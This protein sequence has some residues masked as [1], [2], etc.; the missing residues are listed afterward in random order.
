MSIPDP[1]CL[2]FPRPDPAAA[3]LE[4]AISAYLQS[5]QRR[6][7]RGQ[8]ARAHLDNVTRSLRTFAEAW[9]VGFADG[10]RAVLP[11]A[12]LGPLQRGRV[13]RRPPPRTAG[14]AAAAIAWALELFPGPSLGAQAWRNGETLI[15]DATTD[16]LDL[17][18]VANSQWR[19]Q[20]A[21]A[22]VCAAIL[23]CFGWY[24]DTTGT[25]SPYRRRLAPKFHRERRRNA[26][27]AE[28][29]AMRG[30]GCSEALSLALWCLWHLDGVRPDEM[31]R[32]RWCQFRWRGPD[33]STIE[34]PHKTQRY[35]GKPKVVP[36]TPRAHDFFGELRRTA[37]D[38]VVFHNTKG[39]AWNRISFDGSFRRRR[40]SIGLPDDLTPYC[41]R[42]GY[43]TDAIRGRANKQDVAILLGHTSTRM[44]DEI[45][46]HAEEYAAE[47][48]GRLCELAREVEAKVDA[49]RQT[50]RAKQAEIQGELF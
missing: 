11:A 5:L 10:R 27:Q 21:Q 45:Y 42:H 43:A 39:T 31:Y 35:T 4:R 13:R 7:L 29:D 8:L 34:V 19:T 28:Y 33:S 24:D 6:A 9:R 40:R 48:A 32:L 20:N 25:R 22:N 18:L 41:F 49:L 17:W 26:T 23:N 16:D 44:L 30:E 14:D 46:S 38:E 47:H 3:T 50:Q 15:A 12:V 37:G 2:P 1:V 36:L